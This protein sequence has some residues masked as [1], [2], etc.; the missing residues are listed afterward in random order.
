[1]TLRQ[2]SHLSVGL[3]A[4]EL[5]NVKRRLE[6]CYEKPN[7]HADE[8]QQDADEHAERQV[9]QVCLLEIHAVIGKC[10]YDNNALRL[11]GLM[12]W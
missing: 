10:H 6:D 7:V 3:N 5:A 11:I 1:V 4:D 9:N 2:L 8:N 12:I